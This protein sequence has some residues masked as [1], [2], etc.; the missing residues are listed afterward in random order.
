V[1]EAG[2]AQRTALPH[3]VIGWPPPD[4]NPYQGLLAMADRFIVTCDSV[5]MIADA[6]LTGRP[7][8]IFMLAIAPF[9]SRLSSRGLGLSLDMRRRRRQ[10]AN[11]PDDV[12]DRLRDTLVARHLMRPWDDLRDVMHQLERS[13]LARTGTGADADVVTID[14]SSAVTLQQRELDLI[15]GRIIELMAATARPPA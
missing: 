4:P 13:G 14:M 1:L 8:K 11:Q 3:R 2:L 10:R 7:V 6:S 15:R 12:L 9:K 5:S